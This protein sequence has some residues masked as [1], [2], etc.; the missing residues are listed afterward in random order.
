MANTTY[1]E[2]SKLTA[3]QWAFY[4]IF[5]LVSCLFLAFA[6]ALPDGWVPAVTYAI[7]MTIIVFGA[8]DAVTIIAIRFLR[9]PG[10]PTR[11]CRPRKYQVN[12][13]LWIG[14][15]PAC[16]PREGNMDVAI[17]QLHNGQLRFV[18]LND[19]PKKLIGKIGEWGFISFGCYATWELL[20][21]ILGQ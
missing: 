16:W 6:Y 15:A 2:D 20:L 5:P 13:V 10:S 11:L 7:I 8:I 9:T 14:T 12:E 19:K 3:G 21:K 18:I 4:V 17:V 1:P